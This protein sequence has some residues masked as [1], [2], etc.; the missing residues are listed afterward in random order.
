MADGADQNYAGVW[1]TGLGFGEKSAIIVIDLLQGFTIGNS[2]GERASIACAWFHTPLLIR[3]RPE[4][5]LRD[6]RAF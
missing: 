3:L 1:D 5:V 2:L 4:P 6:H